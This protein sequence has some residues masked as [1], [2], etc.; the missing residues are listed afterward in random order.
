MP[1]VFTCMNEVENNPNNNKEVWW[2]PAVQ[3]F[4]QVSTWIVAPIVLAL[5]FGK[6]L[7]TRYG[8][9]P[10]IFLVLA[11]LGFLI[12]CV[13]MYRV[14]KNYIKKIQ[15]PKEGLNQE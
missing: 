1:F 2:K 5:V 8:T 6:M 7:D 12:T 4:A 14:I 13:G 3:L 9:K 11:G 15:P 10:I